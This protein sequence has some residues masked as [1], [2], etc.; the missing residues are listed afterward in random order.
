MHKM[1]NEMHEKKNENKDVQNQFSKDHIQ[2]I[3]SLKNIKRDEKPVQNK[4]SLP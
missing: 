4:S 2:K 3:Q 1:L